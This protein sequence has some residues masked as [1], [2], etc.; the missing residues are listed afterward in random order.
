MIVKLPILL[1]K[2]IEELIAQASLDTIAEAREALSQ[3][4][5]QHEKSLNSCSSLITSDVQRLS[6]LVTRMPATYAAVYA[7]MEEVFKIVP[8]LKP[9]SLLDLGSGPG[10]VL[11]V[12]KTVLE[13]LEKA[14][15]IEK[16]N[17]LIQLGKRLLYGDPSILGKSIEWV[18]CDLTDSATHYAAHDLVVC[19]YAIGELAKQKL[20]AVVTKAWDATS[21]IL[22]FIEPGTPEGFGRIRAI[23]SLLLEKKA[24][25]I[26]PCTHSHTC[27]LTNSDWCHFS[28]R[29]QRSKEHRF[30]K[31]GELMYEDE[32]FSY[33]A[34]AKQP[35]NRFCGEQS[36]ILRHPLKRTGHLQLELCSNQG[37]QKVVVSKRQKQQYQQARDS[38]WGD[39]WELD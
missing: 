17:S 4:Y 19:S 6:Y 30:A 21:Q 23:R 9:M 20:E 8:H 18:A 31:S 2:K 25:I 7:V 27:P 38:E 12:A 14:T 11:W 5:R 24:Y 15:L 33:I 35:F 3:I 16:D 22:I 13:N 37:I 34:V 28:Q 32:K 29:L 39:I 36:R 1:Q 26:A 10:T